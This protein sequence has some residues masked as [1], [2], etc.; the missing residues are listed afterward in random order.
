LAHEGGGLRGDVCQVV[1]GA[2]G[3]ERVVRLALE[4]VGLHR[5]VVQPHPSTPDAG[6]GVA[7]IELIRAYVL[8]AP[9]ELGQEPPV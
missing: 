6:L 9:Q 8:L 1:D 7:E 2:H 3:V 4:A 5:V